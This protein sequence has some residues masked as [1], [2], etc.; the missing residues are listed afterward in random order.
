MPTRPVP[1]FPR[2]CRLSSLCSRNC[3]WPACETFHILADREIS[4]KSVKSDLPETL[5]FS[6]VFKLEIIQISV[7]SC[8]CPKTLK[9]HARVSPAGRAAPE[10]GRASGPPGL[11]CAE[12]RVRGSGKCVAVVT[13]EKQ[14]L[15]RGHLPEREVAGQGRAAGPRPAV[16]GPRGGGG[17]HLAVSVST[18]SCLLPSP[19][20]PAVLS[21]LQLLVAAPAWRAP[22]V[23][24]APQAADEEARVEGPGQ[25]R[26]P[27]PASWASE[28]RAGCNAPG[29]CGLE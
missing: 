8:F 16:S 1:L 22:Q 26:V 24:T 5:S 7:A 21:A 17:K 23:G 12:G 9:S 14:S 3:T 10:G 15:D 4:F 2:S 13:G 19:L 29:A 6:L 27:C 11:I 28:D 25:S 20:Q 18:G